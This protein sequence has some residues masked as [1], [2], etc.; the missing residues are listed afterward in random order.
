MTLLCRTILNWVLT[1]TV[2]SVDVYTA[3]SRSSCWLSS[4]SPVVGVLGTSSPLVSLPSPVVF[5]QI[6]LL[7]G[8]LVSEFRLWRRTKRYLFT[9][10]DFGDCM[11]ILDDPWISGSWW[12]WLWT[13]P[14]SPL[15]LLSPS[16]RTLNW[17]FYQHNRRTQRHTHTNT[18]SCIIIAFVLFLSISFCCAYHLF[19][20][21]WEEKLTTYHIYTWVK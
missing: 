10:G 4:W 7:K 18:H 1:S 12:Y 3:E 14:L 15:L 6:F 9:H 21:C 17:S 16:F 13:E 19:C 8:F 11:F 20:F 5:C 2:R